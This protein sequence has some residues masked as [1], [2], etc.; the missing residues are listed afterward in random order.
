MRDLDF[1]RSQVPMTK[2][3]VR[4]MALGLLSLYQAKRFLDIGAGTGSV[5]VTAKRWH[6]HLEVVGIERKPEALDLCRVNA[7]KAKVAIDWLQGE[8]PIAIEGAF[9]AI[10]VGGTGGH[11]KTLLPWIMTIANP[12]CRLVLT[13][14]TLEQFTQ[15]L[16]CLKDHY[17]H[18][19]LEIFNLQ[20]QV[21]TPL[22]PFTHFKPQNPTW[23][24]S[25]SINQ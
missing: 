18:I 9:D 24:I 1:T 12:G 2:E 6:P 10:F 3:G 7:S 17:P 14:I 16:Q 20:V 25:F 4:Y 11:I 22:G 21:A 19:S 23:L 5:A 13:F 8:A 15:T